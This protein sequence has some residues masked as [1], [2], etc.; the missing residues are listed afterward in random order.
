MK[1]LATV[2]LFVVA[3][4]G[5]KA[6][7]PAAPTDKP[8]AAALPDLPF[9]KLTQEQRGQFM[10][11]KVMPAMEPI[12]ASHLK[13]GE[14]FTCKT[15]HGTSVDKEVFDMPNADIVALNFADMSKY[16]KEDLEWMGKQVKPAMAKLLGMPEFEPEHPDP[17]AFGCLQ[18]HTQAK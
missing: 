10:K 9:E 11:E 5:S 1:R 12:F 15:C 6:K 8:A 17:K 2:L 18:C 7:G 13:A 14:K 4:C 16:K 3:A